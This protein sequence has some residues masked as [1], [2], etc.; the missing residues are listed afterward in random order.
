[1]GVY[2][3]TAVCSVLAYLWLIL[4]LLGPTPDV[5]TLTE[6]L[7]TLLFFPLFVLIA[8]ACDV[9]PARLARRR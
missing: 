2:G 3:C 6:A 4:I 7:A 1:M 5:I 8:Y 9:L